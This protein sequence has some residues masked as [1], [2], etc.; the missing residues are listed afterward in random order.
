[1]QRVITVDDLERA[2]VAV[3][4]LEIAGVFGALDESVSLD[5]AEAWRLVA[6]FVPR[7]GGWRGARTPVG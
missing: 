3:G 7:L 6:V 1:M 2:V 4:S 5:D